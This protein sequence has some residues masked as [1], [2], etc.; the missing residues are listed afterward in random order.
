[1]RMWERL[2]V[3]YRAITLGDFP[4]IQEILSAEGAYSAGPAVTETTAKNIAAVWRAV[5]LLST[6]VAAL[7]LIP[8]RRTATGRE[9]AEGTNLWR[10]LHLEPNS[11]TSPFK[12]RESIM[13]DA[14]L[15][16]GGFAEIERDQASRPMA[17]HYIPST[18]VQ[19]EVL[20]SGERRYHVN[21]RSMISHLDMLDV[22]PLLGIP[23]I[24]V[25]RL[26]LSVGL[27][28]DQ[29][30]ASFFRNSAVP[31][32]V[33]EHPGNLSAEAKKSLRDSVDSY[34][35]GPDKHYKTLVTEEGIKV[36]TFAINMKD[37]QFLESKAFSVEEV[38]RWF[39]LPPHKLGHK[40]GERPGGNLEASQLE[41]LSDS[42]RP[43]L[44]KI[45]QEFGRKL[46]ARER[47]STVYLEHLVDAILR[48]DSKTR[49]QMI[50]E[51]TGGPYRTLNEGR[52]LENLPAQ[53][54]GDTIGRMEEQPVAEEDERT[55]RRK[56]AAYREMVRSVAARFVR[57]EMSGA[58]R[59][60]KRGTAGFGEWVEELEERELSILAEFLR[61][62]VAYRL[63]ELEDERPPE[64][65]SRHLARQHLQASR[66]ELLALPHNELAEGV[67]ALGDQW[68][69]RRSAEIVGSVLGLGENNAA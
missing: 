34:H 7:P 30:S 60:A 16:K 31:G 4:A 64:E 29:H 59:A 65:V 32:L 63:A 53:P 67:E 68:E 25:A 27:A 20:K 55:R 18:D 28:L 38:A 9:R 61:P 5:V 51:S 56:E 6:Q 43:W 57:R 19:I 10:L 26:S 36:Q 22:A 13:H 66:D 17:L 39:N 8:Y 44:I 33:L 1:M 24:G 21:G 11:Y 35:R 45:E 2:R 47:R 58:K 3:A 41:F 52:T 14:L 54:G 12:L 46:I 48:V 37:S 42:L 50:L 15:T 40:M 23:P 49:H 69:V 62:L